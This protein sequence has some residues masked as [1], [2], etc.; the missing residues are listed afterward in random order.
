MAESLQQLARNQA[1]FREVNERIRE[2][3]EVSEACPTEFLC[4]CGR[5]DCIVTI[6][7]DREEYE[8]IRSSRDSFLIAPGHQTAGEGIIEEN[9]RFARVEKTNRPQIAIGADPRSRAS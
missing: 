1:L 8:A 4:E 6:A 7:L 5:T 3:A 2:L 9:E